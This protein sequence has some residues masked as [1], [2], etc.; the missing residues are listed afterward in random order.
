MIFILILILIFLGGDSLSAII[1]VNPYETEE[2]WLN[3]ELLWDEIEQFGVIVGARGV[4]KTYGWMDFSLDRGFDTI[5]DKYD[6]ETLE[7]FEK[8]PE[9]MKLDFQFYYLR[10]TGTQAEAAA[11]DLML[12]DF[13]IDFVNSLNEEILEKY[14]YYIEYTGSKKGPRKIYLVFREKEEKKKRIRKS[15]LLGRIAALSMAEKIRGPGVPEIKIIIVDEFQAKKNWDYL[16]NEPAELEDIYESIGR[17]RCG[18]GDIKVVLLGNSGT[19]LNPYFDYY[20]YDEFTELKTVKK[21]GEAV[22]YHLPNKAKRSEKSK[23]LFKGSAYG[24]YSLDND[25]ADN[26]MFN[27]LR[28]KDAVP[29]RKCLYNVVIGDLPMGIWKTGDQKILISRITD[30]DKPTFVDRMPINNEHQDIQPYVILADK[31]AHKTLHFDSPELRLKSEKHLRRYV[32]HRK[33]SNTWEKF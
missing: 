1:T 10:R 25:Y 26:Q 16:P 23:N 13:Y 2:G 9:E 14:D 18:T 24:K 5:R 8:L 21:G 17:I 4:G 30:D 6:F 3:T 7:E 11:E 12:E 15:I 32:Y 22:F 28:L 19:I 31:V 33:S 27:V 29:P 20:D